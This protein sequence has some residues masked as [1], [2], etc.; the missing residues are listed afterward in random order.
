[1]TTRVLTIRSSDVI[2]KKGRL[3]ADALAEI[4]RNVPESFPAADER[5]RKK[6][7]ARDK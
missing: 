3:T 6:G 5:R 7:L 4:T 2:G 1:M